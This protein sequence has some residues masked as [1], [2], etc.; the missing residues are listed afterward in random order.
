M[1]GFGRSQAGLSLMLSDAQID[2]PLLQMHKPAKPSY[3]ARPQVLGSSVKVTIYP[4]AKAAQPQLNGFDQAL[5]LGYLMGRKV[6][7]I[8]RLKGPKNLQNPEHFDYVRWCQLRGI[9]AKGEG[10]LL[11]MIDKLDL[12]LLASE[13]LIAPQLGSKTSSTKAFL[14]HVRPAYVLVSADKNNSYGHP[15][16]NKTKAYWEQGSQWYNTG[17]HGQIKMVF[18]PT[19]EYQ[20]LRFSP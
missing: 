20:V 12:T 16:K 3:L 8:V 5:G 19:G 9:E 7:L 2:I 11:E 6:E 17:R 18:N 14:T 13:V 15:H 10:K 1:T 4:F